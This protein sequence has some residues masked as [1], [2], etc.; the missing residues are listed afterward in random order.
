MLKR[1]G[2]RILFALSLVFA[3]AHAAAAQGE[4][5]TAF[6][7]LLDNSGSL[8]KRWPQA[9]AL[10][11]EAVRRV[12]P[13]GPVLLFDFERDEGD[14]WG[15]RLGVASDAEWGLDESALREKIDELTIVRG[16]Q[17]DIYGAIR[18]MAE[19]VNE[20]AASERGAVGDKVIILITDGKDTLRRHGGGNVIVSQDEVDN[21]RK[22][23]QRVIKL[24][25]ES[26]IKVYAVA[27]TQHLETT[28]IARIISPKGEAEEF[29]RKLTKETGGR[30][31]FPKKEAAAD[32]VLGELLAR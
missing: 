1:V 30:V 22:E 23:R 21:S 26:G 11:K 4:R 16:R 9:A 15:T 31:V 14:A 24:L 19:A 32:G 20:K 7:V 3:S 12:R 17:K 10:G 13:R 27:F 28:S 5:K 25:K 8:E 18:A 6:T 2:P 29:L